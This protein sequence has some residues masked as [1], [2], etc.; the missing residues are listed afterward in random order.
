ME[1]IY[2]YNKMKHGLYHDSC[3]TELRGA[4]PGSVY[5]QRRPQRSAPR[6]GRDAAGGRR[7]SSPRHT[8]P[9]RPP[10][11]RSPARHPL[12]VS[13]PRLALGGPLLGA[14][15]GPGGDRSA[16]HRRLCPGGAERAPGPCPGPAA[17]PWQGRH[18]L[19]VCCPAGPT[20][21]YGVGRKK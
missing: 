5:E 12:G 7:A 14:R 19:P 1:K 10:R 3:V 6:T 15:L 8:E 16:S 9:L 13:A 21:K 18:S 4:Q 11:P 17:A 20:Q 2:I